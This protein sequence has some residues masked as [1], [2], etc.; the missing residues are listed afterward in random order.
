MSEAPAAAIPDFM[1]RM[2]ALNTEKLV[3]MALRK[4]EPGNKRGNTSH[5]WKL[6][7]HTR[8]LA[9]RMHIVEN[10]SAAAI[11]EALADR[12]TFGKGGKVSERVL[13][14]WLRSIRK[15]YGQ[16][17]DAQLS[18]ITSAET[19][20]YKSGDLVALLGITFASVVPKFIGY[21][22][23]CTMAEMSV[24]EQHV[25]LRFLETQTTAAKVQAEVREREAR[26]LG[27]LGKIREAT[28]D[29][30]RGARD[31]GD[32]LRDITGLLDQ[33]TGARTGD[34]A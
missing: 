8:H 32:V 17:H 9:A 21:I 1:Q 30:E 27:L 18:E 4:C 28:K 22:D 13:S 12:M 6:D 23:G 5:C 19:I 25:M 24:S 31:A 34:A 2:D 26:T 14:T 7:P 15:A 29:G 11:H 3:F 16:L 20:A 10:K 33:L